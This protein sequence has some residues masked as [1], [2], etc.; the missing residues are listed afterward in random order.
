MF[1]EPKILKANFNSKLEF[2]K[3][4]IWFTES[5]VYRTLL[6][7]FSGCEGSEGK[8]FYPAYGHFCTH[9]PISV[10]LS[11]SDCHIRPTFFQFS[12]VQFHSSWVSLLVLGIRVGLSEASYSSHHQ[13][14]HL[15][16][17]DIKYW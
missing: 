4:K 14:V 5:L 12:Q 15:E 9:E 11:L 6:Y 17:Q 1:I 10:N 8:P 2:R 3:P 13:L 7:K 16:R